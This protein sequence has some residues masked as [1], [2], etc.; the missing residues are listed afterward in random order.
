MYSPG[1]AWRSA[2]TSAVFGRSGVISHL[3][4]GLLADGTWYEGE[5]YHLFAHRGLWYGVT[6]AEVAGFEIP[7]DLVQ[8]FEKGFAAPFLTALPDFTFPS[9]RDSQYAVSLRQSRSTASWA[10]LDARIPFYSAPSSACIVMTFL[11][12]TRVA[13]GHRRTSSETFLPL[14]CRVPTSVGAH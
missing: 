4:N 5:N 12:A 3:E 14:R 11:A 10:W 8:R 6:L 7:N 2:A 9:R 1:R 13:A